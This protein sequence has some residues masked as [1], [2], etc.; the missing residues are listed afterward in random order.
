MDTPP[1]MAPTSAQPKTSGLA[2][3]A[4]VCGI[5]GFTTAGLSGLAGIIMGHISLSSIKKSG[6]AL[7]GKGM[8]IAGLICGYL[9]FLILPVAVIAGLVSPMILRQKQVAERTVVISNVK[10]LGLSMISFEQAFEGFPKDALAD[11]VNKL[12][13]ATLP[14]TGSDVLNQLE[15][16][17]V[18]NLS[19]YLTVPDYAEG[20]WTYFPDAGLSDPLLVSPEMKGKLVVLYPD[21]SVLVETSSGPLGQ[22]IEQGTSGGVEIPAIR[23]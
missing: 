12:T 3:G 21:V 2:I 6:G 23:K 14:M 4:L 18:E 8:A 16:Y 1:P 10:T 13:G 5:L 17:S 19:E 22:S 11:E 7:S 9:S 20:N 15:A